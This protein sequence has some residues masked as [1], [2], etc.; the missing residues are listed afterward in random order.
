M[1]RAG[2]RL[3]HI[4]DTVL[5]PT[6]LKLC[7]FGILSALNGRGAALPSVQELAEELVLDR[8]T[9]GQNLRPL[10]RDDLVTLLTDPRDRRVRLIALTKSGI[11]KYNEARPYWQAAQERFEAVFGEDEAAKLRSVLLSIAYN[12]E[13]GK[14]RL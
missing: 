11:A 13:L 8:S 7:Q 12:P 10:E 1:R 3:L 4:Y 9:L 2:R 6:G 5:A 14:S